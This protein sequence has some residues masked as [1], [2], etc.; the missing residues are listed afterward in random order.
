MKIR[1]L[2]DNHDW[3]LGH[4]T[5]TEAI[6]Q[7]VKIAVLTLFGDWFLNL[8]DGVKW[9]RYL[10]KNPNI[11]EL[12]AELKN[13]VLNVSGVSV[14]EQLSVHFDAN[15]RTAKIEISYTDIFNQKAKVD[16]NYR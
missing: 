12:Q 5:N 13:A 10:A 3:Q 15:E 1:A 7:N 6:A 4:K 16:A 2:D 11:S 9:F 14:L 8:D